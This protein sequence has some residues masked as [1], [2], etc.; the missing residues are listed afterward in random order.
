MQYISCAKSLGALH[1]A[2]FGNHFD[3]CNDIRG[4]YF[5]KKVKIIPSKFCNNAKFFP[6][7][8]DPK[9]QKSSNVEKVFTEN[10]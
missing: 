9:V 3:L 5:Y 4:K 10:I 7:P 2:H 8:K 1:H 6:R